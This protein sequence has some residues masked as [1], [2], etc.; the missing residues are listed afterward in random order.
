MDILKIAA[1]LF[2]SN[3]NSSNLDSGSVMNGLKG[4][5][6]DQSGN[7]DLTGLISKFGS[8]GLGALTSS[9]L[10]NGSNESLST[11]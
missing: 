3:S 10:G 5:L 11:Q 8:S 9:W 2:I 6:A 4:L 1:D 7:I